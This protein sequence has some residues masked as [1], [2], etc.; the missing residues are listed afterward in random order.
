MSTRPWEKDVRP[1]YWWDNIALPN[2]LRFDRKR[3]PHNDLEGL[4]EDQWE[5]ALEEEPPRSKARLTYPGGTPKAGGHRLTAEEWR[6]VLDFDKPAVETKSSEEK[7]SKAIQGAEDEPN[8]INMMANED[9]N[10]TLDMDEGRRGATEPP[11]D[12]LTNLKVRPASGQ[13]PHI[14]VPSS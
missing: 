6:P 9:V 2:Y 1:R 12:V 13:A 14:E 8:A 3:S 4:G 10:I 5:N 11:A 7:E